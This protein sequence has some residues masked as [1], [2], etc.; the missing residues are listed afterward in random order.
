MAIGWWLA[1]GSSSG[2]FG[3]VKAAVLVANLVF[4]G[5]AFF[6]GCNHEVQDP[7]YRTNCSWS[8]G[9]HIPF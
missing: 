3:L 5:W 9:A 6:L 7:R 8:F 1:G 4:A 2:N